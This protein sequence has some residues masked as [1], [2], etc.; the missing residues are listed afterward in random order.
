LALTVTKIGASFVSLATL[1]TNAFNIIKMSFSRTKLQI[2]AESKA[3]ALERELDA[4]KLA[5]SESA[6]AQQSA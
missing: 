5:A 1:V 3:A 2:M 4:A 6:Y